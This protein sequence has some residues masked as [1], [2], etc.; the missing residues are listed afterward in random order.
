VYLSR[1]FVLN[2]PGERPIAWF[3]PSFWRRH[4]ARW[5]RTMVLSII[6]YSLSGI[7]REMMKSTWAGRRRRGKYPPA[8]PGALVFW[9]L[10]AA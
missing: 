5:A 6:A 9:P 8:K 7:G 2:P 1:I 10:K 4:R 3:S